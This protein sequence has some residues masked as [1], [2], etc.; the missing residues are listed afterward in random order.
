MVTIPSARLDPHAPGDAMVSMFRAAGA[1]LLVDDVVHFLFDQWEV[2][3]PRRV[4]VAALTAPDPSP[5][6]QAETK[7]YLRVL[8]QE[9]LQ[10]PQ[11]QRAALLLNLRDSEG[12]NAAA[13]LVL[14]G[15]TDLDELGQTMGIGCRL[16]VIW[17][18]LPLDDLSIGAM[19]GVTRQQV[20]NLRKSARARL[21][22][23]MHGRG[24]Q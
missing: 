6:L 22:R 24:R 3:A 21:A 18:Q 5:A 4:D 2:H 12:R 19:L 13:L 8:W 10:L 16:A 7:Q 11:A 9:V 20:I 23:R 1:P 14:L 15:V 17:S